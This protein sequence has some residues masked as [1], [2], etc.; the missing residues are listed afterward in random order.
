MS[1]IKKPKF[2]KSRSKQASAPCLLA[3]FSYTVAYRLDRIADIELQYGH[4]RAAERL[5]HQATA[6]RR[7][8]GERGVIR[9]G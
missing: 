2:R 7:P 8:S 9:H 3:V 5:A 1:D 6:L 4:W